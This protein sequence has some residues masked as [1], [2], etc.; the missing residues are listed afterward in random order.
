MYKFHFIFL[1]QT[2]ATFDPSSPP[3]NLSELD[4]INYQ[5]IKYRSFSGNLFRCQSYGDLTFIFQ[6]INEWNVTILN[7]N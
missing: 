6:I 5:G 1:K 3:T 2:S 4:Y 7:Q